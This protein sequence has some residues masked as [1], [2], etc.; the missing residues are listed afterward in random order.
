MGGIVILWIEP[1]NPSLQIATIG[2]R[3]NRTLLDVF[4]ARNVMR[5]LLSVSVFLIGSLA[6][7]GGH[8][9]MVDATGI[10]SGRIEVGSGRL[11][12]YQASGARTYF[13]RQPR[14][15]SADGQY[16]GYFNTDFNRVLR[17]PRS[18][19]GYLQTADLDDVAPRFRA[20]RF[21]VQPSGPIAG[22]VPIVGP[23][24]V[25]GFRGRPY[26]GY[27]PQSV[28]IDSQTIPNPP[29]PPARVTFGND[30][31]REVQVGIVDLKNPS[32]TRTTRIAPGAAVEFVLERDSGAKRV[33][34]YR[35]VSPTGESFTKEIVAE[36]P[37]A[38]RYE[39]VVH[40]WAVQSVAIDRTGKSPNR[41]ED[42][43]FQGKGIGRFSLPPG[44]QL[45][46][47]TID[48]Y[49]AARNQ[50]NQGL[51]AP[52]VPGLQ[53][54]EDKAS[55]LDRAIFEAQRAALSEAQR[56]AQSRRP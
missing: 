22:P 26:G 27:P 49:S 35:V 14:Y 21:A 39:V 43:N 44:S 33:A 48:V 3:S 16:V 11:V 9:D 19:S 23:S 12:V 38:D 56:A 25:R 50:G 47:G 6:A 29:L 37:A 32:G 8:F 46:S 15:D 1:T 51:V 36:V 4:H 45:A 13:S 10:A 55:K 28:L 34:H 52:I 17:F 53:R 5:P 7:H 20:S 18:G 30:G 54:P 31:P 42:I 40:E 24:V 41:I 2:A